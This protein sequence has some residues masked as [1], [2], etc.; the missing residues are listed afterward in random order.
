LAPSF[1][2]AD[3]P[4]AR[5]G[6]FDSTF[7]SLRNPGYRLLSLIG[8]GMHMGF[9]IMVTAQGLAA[10]DLTGNSR[11]VGFVQ[12][13]QGSAML[14]LAPF[15]GAVAD[16]VSKRLI[17]IVSM[18]IMFAS[19]VTV[20]ILALID[21]LSIYALA[22]NSF[23]VGV[24]GSFFSPARTAYIGDLV[25]PR[26]HGNAVAVTQIFM[27]AARI[28]GPFVAA[29][30]LAIAALRFGGVFVIV[31]CFYGVIFMMT[32]WLPRPRPGQRR[33][34][35][36]VL[37]DMRLGLRHI[38][39]SP[40]LL[41]LLFGFTIILMVGQPYMVIMPAFTKDVLGAGDAGFGIAMGMAA[42]GG[43]TTS[44]IVAA[45][46]DSRHA[47]T[48][49]HASSFGFGG[50]LLL[51]AATPSFAVLLLVMV[52]VGAFS[53][54]F[55]VLGS[56]VALRESTPEY[57]GRLQSLI[58]IGFSLV[59]VTALLF[60]AA[61]DLLGER[62]VLAAMGGTT[63]AAGLSLLLWFHFAT[64]RRLPVAV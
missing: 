61:A 13:G 50:G 4:E 36:G 44:L 18:G 7:G 33:R 40:R 27:N 57:Y 1:A 37:T 41:P 53:S 3:A 45:L 14:F 9:F 12:F 19:M 24:S 15:G 25:G 62:T 63:C 42:V 17:F 30:L 29:G 26:Q 28:V 59:H 2:E 43:L 8:L 16:R 23:A 39:N 10:H 38:A 11:A 5:A 35:V 54:G 6:W 21:Q 32:L 31:S 55:Q 47:Y 60:G 49:L 52:I 22:A 51:L 46:A 34:R 58:N 56:A 48:M 20:A 64:R